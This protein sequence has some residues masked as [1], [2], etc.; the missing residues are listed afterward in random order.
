MGGICT[1]KQTSSTSI[2]ESSQEE[3]ALISLMTDGVMPAYFDEAGYELTKEEVPIEKDPKYQALKTK[4]KAALA[5]LNKAK[6]QP[7]QKPTMS[8]GGQVNYGVGGEPSNKAQKQKEY[9]DAVN[10]MN[11]YSSN[12]VPEV[13]YKQRKKGSAETEAILEKYGPDSIKYKAAVAKELKAKIAEEKTIN[14]ITKKGYEVV[15][16]YLSGDYSVTTEQKNLIAENNAPIKAAV[17]SLYN[18]TI[19][20]LEKSSEAMRKEAK[21]TKAEQIREIEITEGSLLNKL[22]ETFQ[23]YKAAIKDTSISVLDSLSAVG[24]QILETGKGMEDSLKDVIG[25]NKELLKIG[26]EDKTGEL[27]RRVASNAALLGRSPDD[28]EYQ[29]EIQT[30]IAKEIKSG[31]LSLSSMEAQG[32]LSI[33]ERTGSQLEQML[34]SKAQFLESHGG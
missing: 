8:Y 18:D 21:T 9:D 4:T 27:T 14:E 25:A 11:D 6:T 17:E 34:M 31:T 32:M 30:S 24:S 20:K 16:K 15:K 2:P 3:K 29:Q 12:Y 5:S 33:R 1:S 23:N 10:E 7:T 26:I 22:S 13:T 28:P 19:S